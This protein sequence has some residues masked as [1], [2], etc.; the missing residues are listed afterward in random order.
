ME[1]ARPIQMVGEVV[2]ATIAEILDPP[3]TSE[4]QERFDEEMRQI[5]EAERI[6]PE[7]LARRLY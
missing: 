4:E 5:A 3:A 1:H 7:D 6:T 2:D